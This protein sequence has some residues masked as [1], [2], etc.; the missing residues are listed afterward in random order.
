MQRELKGKLVRWIKA[1][2]LIGLG[3]IVLAGLAVFFPMRPPNV[4]ALPLVTITYQATSRKFDPE[5]R[6]GVW[7]DARREG[8]IGIFVGD[9]EVLTCACAA[10]WR[11][12]PPH[13]M[14]PSLSDY[15]LDPA[16]EETESPTRWWVRWKFREYPASPILVIPK[17]YG[18]VVLRVEG[19]SIR[20]FVPIAS[21]R[22]RA[23]AMVWVVGNRN[24]ADA[25]SKL[26]VQVSE[27]RHQRTFFRQD[28]R[29]ELTLW[30]TILGAPSHTQAP[31]Q[32]S[33][34]PSSHLPCF[35]EGA[36]VFNMRKEL[37][38][39]LHGIPWSNGQSLCWI[40]EPLS[41]VKEAI[42]AALQR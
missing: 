26:V 20:H 29:T 35:P 5:R 41:E 10:G 30:L 8:G 14:A 32:P 19:L 40:M 33:Q 4:D 7:L 34:Q 22:P 23:S 6:Q 21:V 13:R 2:L 25:V 9:N 38:G 11:P 36:P 37:C 42:E 24:S 12:Y 3:G 31:T 15:L 1:L 17:G 28:T 16:E 39:V 18:V 27:Q